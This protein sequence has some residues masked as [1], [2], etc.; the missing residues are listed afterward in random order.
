MS[1]DDPVITN[2]TPG[3]ILGIF[4]AHGC[5]VPVTHK[6]HSDRVKVFSGKEYL[7]HHFAH[8]FERM[9]GSTRVADAKN[10]GV[11]FCV[12]SGIGHSMFSNLTS[13]GPTSG[14]PGTSVIGRGSNS[15]SRFIGAFAG[16]LGAV[17]I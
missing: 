2:G 15:L 14:V 5:D 10:R 7:Y 17:G 13:T 8:S 1:C 16:N 9:V 6:H 4:R 11:H 3:L 12:R